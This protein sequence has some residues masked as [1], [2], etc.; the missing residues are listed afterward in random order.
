MIVNQK[1]LQN[2]FF[3]VKI[4]LEENQPGAYR[5]L[6]QALVALAKQSP[7]KNA[8]APEKIERMTAH[9]YK[10]ATMGQ[11]YYVVILNASGKIVAWMDASAYSEGAKFHPSP[12]GPS[13]SFFQS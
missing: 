11:Y 1:G 3:E 4:I 9:P 7:C 10:Q 6:A 2:S 5:M 13:L 8:D 12:F